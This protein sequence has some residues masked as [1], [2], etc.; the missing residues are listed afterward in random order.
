MKKI[1]IFLIIII[2]IVSTV[3]YLYLN[4]INKQRIAQKENIKFEIY[5][6]QEVTGA[7]L[8]T[9]INKAIDTNEQNEVKK[10]NKGRYLD[11]EVNSINIDIKFIDDDVTYN[12]EKIF[13]N[14]MDKFMNYYRDIKFKCVDD[15]YHSKTQKIKYMLLEQI[16]Q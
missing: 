15:Q 7:E 11:N 6:E 9:L 4:N 5:K 10:D 12:I 14:G 2:G 13:N 3:S 1:A 16:T 8:T